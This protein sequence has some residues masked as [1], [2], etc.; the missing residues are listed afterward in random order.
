MCIAH[1]CLHTAQEAGLALHPD[2]VK[3][4]KYA[5]GKNAARDFMRAVR[6]PVA[7]WSHIIMCIYTH[8]SMMFW[9]IKI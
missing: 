8:P 7:A 9:F 5:R 2:S 4:G 6:L 3:L 1:R